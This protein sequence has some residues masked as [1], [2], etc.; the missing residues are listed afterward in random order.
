MDERE[1]PADTPDIAP[2]GPPAVSR[3]SLSGA[4]RIGVAV[5]LVC[6]LLGLRSL[7][8]ATLPYIL[9]P[10]EGIDFQEAIPGLPIPRLLDWNLNQI[11]L[12]LTL[13]QI[14]GISLALASLA[15]FGALWLLA[16]FVPNPSFRLLRMAR[17]PAQDLETPSAPPLPSPMEPVREEPEGDPVTL[18]P[19]GPIPLPTRTA[20]MPPA[21]TVLTVALETPRLMKALTLLL[22]TG[23]PLALL[24]GLSR[25]L[26]AGGQGG[27]LSALWLMALGI[28]L[29]IGF[30]PEG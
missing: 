14:D 1:T 23:L 25:R 18:S 6:T 21:P 22:A 2:E 10:G 20:P 9:A 30:R 28:A 5:A 8:I 19:G 15:L 16:V 26:G 11:E 13:R 27:A 24:G 12:L 4:V 29:W 17:V 7:A 3:R